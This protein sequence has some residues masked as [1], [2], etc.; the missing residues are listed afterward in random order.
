[1]SGGGCQGGESRGEGSAGGGL[2]LWVPFR[3]GVAGGL[4]ERPPAWVEDVPAQRDGLSGQEYRP[5]RACGAGRNRQRA[6]RSGALR[7]GLTAPRGCG[8]MGGQSPARNAEG[9][10]APCGHDGTHQAGA[11]R[12]WPYDVGVAVVVG[13][14]VE[15]GVDVRWNRWGLGSTTAA[16]A[17]ARSP[18]AGQ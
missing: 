8:A 11:E 15:V 4:A 7:Q 16:G 6:K 2:P 1:M 3:S 17:A 18:P 9:L 12:V 5:S 10:L 14:V 13:V